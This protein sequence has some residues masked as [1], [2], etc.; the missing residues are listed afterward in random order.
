[1]ETYDYC[2]REGI[3]M[4]GGGQFELGV[5][6]EQAQLLASIFHADGPN[7]LAPTGWNAVQPT[8]PLLSS[9][10]QL[11]PAATGLRLA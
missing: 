3:R 10:L 2:D 11:S 9:P 8:G 1:M 6:R 4:Y 5:G 7:D